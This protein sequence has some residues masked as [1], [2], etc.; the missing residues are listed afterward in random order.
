MNFGN[1]Q[2]TVKYFLDKGYQL[3]KG[4]LNFL[5]TNPEET[6][7]LA[8]FIDKTQPETTTISQN[9]LNT[10]LGNT[11]SQPEIIRAPEVANSTQTVDAILDHL[12]IRYDY[13]KNLLV[14]RL[15]LTNPTS[16]NKIGNSKQFSIIGLIRE[17]DYD[18]KTIT[19]DDKTGSTTL[20][21]SNLT[22]PLYNDEVVG[23][24]CS[25]ENSRIEIRNLVVPD[26]PIKKEVSRAIKPTQCFFFSDFNLGNPESS[27]CYEKYKIWARQLGDEDAFVFIL[28][29]TAKTEEQLQEL[30][31]HLPKSATP[32]VSDG[33]GNATARLK[34]PTTVRVSNINILITPGD[35]YKKY[36][37]SG[38][39]GIE[40]T[41]INLIKKRHLNPTFD[42]NSTVYANDPYL[43]DIIPDIIVVTGLGKPSATNYK[44]ITVLT[45]GSFLTQP[46]FWNVNLTTRETIKVDF[47]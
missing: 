20:V 3:D 13:I 43:L 9:E 11:Q 32:I 44:G 34:E 31:S 22:I 10:F 19:V 42:K 47:S 27:R 30:I 21:F 7:R 23:F 12:R 24:V 33:N 17:I 2:E 35:F 1:L 46:V 29:N 6:E 26:I 5:Q 37:L 45:T 8:K 18:N 39:L 38:N 36:E 40:S 15:E 25:Q 16:I 14:K 41:F 4:V 28:D